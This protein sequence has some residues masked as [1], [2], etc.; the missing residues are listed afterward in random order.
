MISYRY[1]AEDSQG[2]PVDGHVDAAT[3]EEARRRLEEKGLRVLEVMEAGSPSGEAPPKG[4]LTPDEAHELAENV[5]QLSAAGLPLSPG[6]RAVGDESESPRLASS[7]H[8]LADQLDEGRPLEDVLESSKGLLP[9]YVTGLIRAANRSSQL[10]PALTELAELHRDTAALRYGVWR[11]LAYPLAVAGLGTLLLFLILAFVAGGF[12][13]I[14]DDFD[15]SLPMLT[16]VFFLWRRLALWLVPLCLAAVI[17][18][19]TALRWRLG[20]AGWHRWLAS[21]PVVGPLWHWLCLLEWIG[22]LRV[23]VRH[24]MT[25]LEALRLS[26]GG[27]SNVNVSRLSES[28]AEGV[29]RGRSLS[30]TI[31]A[32]RQMPASL[33]P[34]VRWGEESGSLAESLSMGREMLEERVR[35]R[36]LWLRTA[37]PPLLFIVIGCCV[38]LVVGA[39][40]MPLISLVQRIS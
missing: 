29:A 21:A 6:L 11:G 5:A 38:L 24:G 30:Q 19:A 36:S 8:Y 17:A 23:L 14:F 7:L 16:E 33:V 15:A 35:M 25:L 40:F 34:L 31:A 3:V 27:I 32:E 9:A 18:V 26:A 10:G 1:T 13:R 37:L 12:E 4:R 22:L 39:L 28:L 2:R 20:P